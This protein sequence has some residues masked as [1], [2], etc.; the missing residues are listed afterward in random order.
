MKVTPDMTIGELIRLDENI[1][2]ILM[3]RHALH[4][5]PFRTGRKHC[6]GSYGSRN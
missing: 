6:R 5:M 4:R 2:P 1:V 3:S